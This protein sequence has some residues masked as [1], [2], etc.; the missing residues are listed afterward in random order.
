MSQPIS[1]VRTVFSNKI[2]P[3]LK[4]GLEAAGIN[5]WPFLRKADLIPVITKCVE[6]SEIS[7][8]LEKLSPEVKGVVTAFADVE[9]REVFRKFFAN[10]NSLFPILTG[11]PDFIFLINE[12]V[13]DSLLVR[14]KFWKT[15]EAADTYTTEYAAL[16][17]EI[18]GLI[19]SIIASNPL[20]TNFTVLEKDTASEVLGDP[21]VLKQR[22]EVY[23][24]LPA[25]AESVIAA[26]Q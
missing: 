25:I 22:D 3:A 17:K 21:E 7:E 12:P 26:Y 6:I 9:A 18:D 1:I 19:D 8:E 16:S 23:K 24:L 2:D 4:A 15:K 11:N 5:V 14:A 10:V 13:S 20:Y